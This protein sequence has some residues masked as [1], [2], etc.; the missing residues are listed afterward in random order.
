MEIKPVRNESDY[1][2][3]LKRIETLRDTT[4]GSKKNDER[5]VLVTLVYAYEERHHVIGPEDSI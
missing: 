4:P 2:K 3:A 5:E 1:Q